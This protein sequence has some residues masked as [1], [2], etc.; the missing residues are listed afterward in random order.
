M[1]ISTIFNLEKPQQNLKY[2]SDILRNYMADIVYGANDGIITT[3]TLVSGIEGAKFPAV[4]IIVLGVIN[5]FADGLSMGASS[6]L[7]FRA[8]AAMK[9]VSCG[10]LESFYHGFATF[11]AFIL[12]GAVPLISFLI[13]RFYEYQ[14]LISCI[15]TAVTLFLI[16]ALRVVIIIGQGWLC[17]GLEMLLVGGVAAILGYTIGHALTR[18]FCLPSNDKIL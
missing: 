18:W 15:M 10:Y 11:L 16:G 14:F 5:L 1:A 2:K 12:C 17:G 13:P 4:I 9:G 8:D 3:F 7:S 6:Y